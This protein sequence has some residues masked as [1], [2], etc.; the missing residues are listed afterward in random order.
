MTTIDEIFADDRSNPSRGAF[1]SV[2]GDA[3]HRHRCRRAEAALGIRHEGLPAHGTDLLLLCRLD[4]EWSTRAVLWA[5]R[6]VR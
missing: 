6:H 2:G 3:W 1:A 4:R 5:Y